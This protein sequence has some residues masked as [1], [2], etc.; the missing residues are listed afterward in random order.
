MCVI[1][2]RSPPDIGDDC[3]PVGDLLFV[4]HHCLWIIGSLLFAGEASDK[5]DV[6]KFY[7]IDLVDMS[8]LRDLDCLIIAVAHKAFKN[9]SRDELLGMLKADGSKGVVVDV[10]G[11]RTRKEFEEAGCS[12][13]RL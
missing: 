12:Y 9:L 7:G 3:H 6:K 8:E 2:L 5:D 11:I 4:G 1:C 13:W 10:K